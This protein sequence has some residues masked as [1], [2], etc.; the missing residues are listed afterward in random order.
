MS[1]GTT[2]ILKYHS[3]MVHTGSEKKG[4]QTMAAHVRHRRCQCHITPACLVA[5][6]VSQSCLTD[7]LQ[8]IERAGLVLA[9]TG[10]PN[11]PIA[12]SATK[13]CRCVSICRHG[14]MK[15][16]ALDSH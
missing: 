1:E 4:R 8:L 7:E 12:S 16:A 3:W 2:V 11:T 6:L 5:E 15:A 13:D 14:G 9:Q 10:F